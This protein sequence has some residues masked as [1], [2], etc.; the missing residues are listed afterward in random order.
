MSEI[1]SVLTF[2][3]SNLYIGGISWISFRSK[4]II[5][6]FISLP[7]FINDF[8]TSKK[9]KKFRVGKKKAKKLYVRNR[10]GGNDIYSLNGDFIIIQYVNATIR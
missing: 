1:F 9:N 7:S 4:L 8:L 2:Q 6:V 5:F 3:L 10:G